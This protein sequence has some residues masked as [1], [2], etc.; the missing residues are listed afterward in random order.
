MFFSMQPLHIQ[1][2]TL[3]AIPALVPLINAAYRGDAARKGWTHEAD[4][5]A[6]T[7]RIN[8]GT[9]SEILQQPGVTMLTATREGELLG[10]VYLEAKPAELYLGMLSVHPEQQAG[11]IGR[12]LLEAAEDHARSLGLPAITMT[13]ISVRQELIE[14]YERRGYADTGQRAAFPDDGKF[15]MPREPLEFVVLRKEVGGRR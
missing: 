12:K 6:G 1:P 4:L 11:G 7:E 15:G 8:A 2:A 10:T 3:D 9:L 14:W 5:I 13:V